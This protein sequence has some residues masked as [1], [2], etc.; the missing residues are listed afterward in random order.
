MVMTTFFPSAR[1]EDCDGQ[2]REFHETDPVPTLISPKKL[3][4]GD[5]IVPAA[6]SCKASARVHTSA[7]MLT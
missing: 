2:H 6:C 3:A 4:S 7:T 1:I 5:H